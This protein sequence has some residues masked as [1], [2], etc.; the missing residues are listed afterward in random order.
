M[1]S[2]IRFF[3]VIAFAFALPFSSCKKNDATEAPELATEMSAHSEDQSRVAGEVDDIANDGNTI[4]EEYQSFNGRVSNTTGNICNAT[5][6]VDSTSNPKKITVTYNGLNCQ[7]TRSRTGVV[8]YSLPAG[9]RWKDAGAVLTISIQNLKITRVV[10]NK[11]IIINGTQTITNVT[12]GRLR[13]L[14]VVGNITHTIGSSGLSV[15]FD[16]GM[17]RVWQVAKRRVFS[18]NNG[19]VI[20]TT[21]THTDGSLTGIAE[22]G[23]NRFGA[24]FAT[25]IS[26]PMVIRQD[27][28]FRLVKGQVTHHKLPVTVVVTFGLNATGVPTTCPGAGAYYLKI[29][30]TGPTGNSHQVILPY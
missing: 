16:N 26:E 25:T 10:D 27:C 18:Y 1:R 23:T 12:G 8:V 30:W 9:V 22:W 11:S 13:D 19:I 20:T 29:V 28:A 6:V 15:T 17:Q 7:G 5:V 21:G 24:S 14:A 2:R 4:L 3:V